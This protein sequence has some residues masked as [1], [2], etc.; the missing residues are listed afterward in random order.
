MLVAAAK[1]ASP[2]TMTLKRY[3]VVTAASHWE[4]LV[5]LVQSG[6]EIGVKLATD[7]R[8]EVDAGW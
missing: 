4:T 8:G 7:C 3:R 6:D 1:E 5:D 2:D